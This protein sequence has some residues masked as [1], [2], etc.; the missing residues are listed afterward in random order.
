MFT[1][2]IYNNKI[3]NMGKSDEKFKGIKN[4][5]DIKTD[6]IMV[7]GSVQGPSKR[8]LL[9]VSTLRKSKKQLKRNF[10]FIGV[11]KWTKVK[12]RS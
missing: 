8:Q 6:Y 4:F 5:G 10:E 1:R 11:I 2:I 9:I 3:I 12:G 7:Q